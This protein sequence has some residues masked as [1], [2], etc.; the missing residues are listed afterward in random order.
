MLCEQRGPESW[1]G[2]R[3]LVNPNVSPRQMSCHFQL[4]AVAGHSAHTTC[5][6]GAERAERAAE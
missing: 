1:K 2:E 6:H 5:G 4:E 3:N